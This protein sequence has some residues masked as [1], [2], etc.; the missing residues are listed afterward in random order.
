MRTMIIHL[1]NAMIDLRLATN[2]LMIELRDKIHG[3]TWRDVWAWF[4]VGYGLRLFF[5]VL[6][7]FQV[8]R[9]I[10]AIYRNA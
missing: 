7:A 6:I 10:Y 4:M 1:Q 3:A 2:E 5:T 8:G 9:L